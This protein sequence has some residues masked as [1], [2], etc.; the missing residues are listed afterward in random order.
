MPALL[1]TARA[2]LNRPNVRG[3]RVQTTR[4]F[5]LNARTRCAVYCVIQRS[6]KAPDGGLGIGGTGLKG[7][8][9]TPRRPRKGQ[10]ASSA[11]AT[12]ANRH[13]V[14]I[15]KKGST[16]ALS[17]CSETYLKAFTTKTRPRKPIVQSQRPS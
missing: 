10:S 5:F 15:I 7:L 2:P 9:N 6:T 12:E 13:V 8:S 4:A 16:P 17:L 1:S 3:S 14:H 11:D